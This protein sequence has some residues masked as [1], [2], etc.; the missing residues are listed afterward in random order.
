M[1]RSWPPPLVIDAS[2]TTRFLL[3]HPGLPSPEPLFLGWYQAG[4]RLLVPPLWLAES[5][6]NIRLRHYTGSLTED[7]ADFALE[8]LLLLPVDVI[9]TSAAH[10]RSAL[11][12][13]RRLG[14]A[15]AYDAFYI[16]LAEEFGVDLWTA[17][18]RLANGARQAGAPWVQYFA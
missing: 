15:R 5:V 18:G 8:R 3:P 12:W 11:A 4:V 16:A 13:S 6:S 9:P 7:E 1:Q 10:C 17:D 14:Q 2:L